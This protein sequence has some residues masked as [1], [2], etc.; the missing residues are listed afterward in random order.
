MAPNQTEFLGNG[1]LDFR[2]RKGTMPSLGNGSRTP[3]HNTAGTDEAETTVYNWR[4][5]AKHCTAESCWVSVRGKVYDVTKWL[6]NHPG[7]KEILLLAAGRDITL[8]FDSYHPF[9]T[10]AESVLKKYEIGEVVDTEYPTYKPD[11]GF[12]KECAKRV[13]KYFEETKQNPKNPWPGI[14]RMIL[15]FAVATFSF[16]V[17]SGI[18]FT[19]KGIEI[20]EFTYWVRFLAAGIF[21]VCQALPL[22]HVMHDSSHLAFGNS[23]L[24]WK[25]AGRFC[26]DWYAGANMTSWHN[27]HVIGH[28]IYTNVFEADPDLPEKVENDPRRLVPRQK[29]QSLYK[30]QYLYLPP[31]YGILGLKFRFQDLFETYGAHINGPVRVN[32][33]PLSQW[34]EMIITKIFWAT[35]RIILPLTLTNIFKY[36]SLAMYLT[37]FFVAEFMTGYFLAFNF[38][39]SHV[40][41]ECDYPNGE[42][43]TDEISDEWAVSQVRAC[44]DYSHDNYL[45][46]FFCGALNY[47]VTHHLFPT[48]SQYHYPAIAKIIKEVCKEYDVEY[49]VL[50]DFKSA[51]YAHVKHLYNLGQDGVAAEVHMG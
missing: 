38:Q 32:P 24:W 19:Y 48:V 29:Y 3:R 6:E 2:S 17:M 34:A 40:S 16:I 50:P 10:K 8:A 22:L 35:Y 1:K 51:F 47:Q 4:D 23:E 20:P 33:I 30:W 43:K 9:S 45:T 26:M 5:V 28:H 21:G 27:Q 49:K 46:T 36:E 39:V 7:G 37:F 14:W 12:Y 42:E 15:V 18:S 31:L 25:I 13:K 44:V 41:T 11:S